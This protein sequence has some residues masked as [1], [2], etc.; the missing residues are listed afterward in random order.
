MILLDTTVLVDILRGNQEVTHFMTELENRYHLRNIA[1]ISVQEL[2]KGAHLS[3]RT[4][5]EL[6]K[7]EELVDCVNV[8][9]FDS[10]AAKIAGKI[11]ADL[12]RRGT[13]IDIQDVQIAAIAIQHN[14]RIITRNVSHFSKIKGLQ[15]ETY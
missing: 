4:E 11:E 12:E 14:M 8:I 10:A 3:N 13:L 15:I 6:L 7:I 5:K 2:C 9:L 1:S